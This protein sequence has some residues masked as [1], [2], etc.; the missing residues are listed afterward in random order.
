MA[1]ILH[2]IGSFSLLIGFCSQFVVLYGAIKSGEKP[3]IVQA[4]LL[5]LALGSASLA[6]A[7]RPHS[8]PQLIPDLLG[9]FSALLLFAPAVE[10]VRKMMVQQKE[11]AKKSQ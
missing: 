3:A 6:L 1:N 10:A 4:V 11:D 2:S 5:L 8:P 9:C 7:L